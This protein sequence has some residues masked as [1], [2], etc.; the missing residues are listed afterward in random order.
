[1]F[2]ETHDSLDLAVDRWT[3]GGLYTLNGDVQV[4]LAAAESLLTLSSG[5]ISA[6]SDQSVR[7]DITIV[8]DDIDFASGRNKVSGSGVLTIQARTAGQAYRIGGAAPSVFARHQAVAG[9][10]VFLAPAMRCL[11]APHDGF[12]DHPL[13][14]QHSRSFPDRG[15]PE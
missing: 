7:G 5:V 2:I 6:S 4:T 3:Q 8:A 11:D 12:P 15:V 10:T 13:S 9:S 1:M 14:N